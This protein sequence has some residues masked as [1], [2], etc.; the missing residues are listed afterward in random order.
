MPI[1]KNRC[2]RLFP[3]HVLC[4][5]VH[6]YGGCSPECTYM[7]LDCI[8]AHTSA[9]VCACEACVCAEARAPHLSIMKSCGSVR[10]A[11]LRQ[12]TQQI[13][14]KLLWPGLVP[15]AKHTH[16]Q[17]HTHTHRAHCLQHNGAT[18]HKERRV[19]VWWWFSTVNTTLVFIFAPKPIKTYQRRCL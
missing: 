6:A 16:T 10:P 3:R 17:K 5:C 18:V 9:R 8:Y 1:R 12:V 4:I 2:Q 13:G 11:R 19:C 15:H 7:C 14:T